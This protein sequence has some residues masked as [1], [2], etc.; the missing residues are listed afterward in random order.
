MDLKTKLSGH[1]VF[2]IKWV[3]RRK[4]A[5]CALK[6]LHNSDQDAAVR[7]FIQIF[8]ENSSQERET[9]KKKH[10]SIFSKCIKFLMMPFG[11]LCEPV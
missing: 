11:F 4:H 5:F 6:N 8:Y 9:K 3:K 7:I 2:I 10:A 1:G